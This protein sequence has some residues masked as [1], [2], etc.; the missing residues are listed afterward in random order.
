MLSIF[1]V[2]PLNHSPFIESKQHEFYLFSTY[3]SSVCTI[4][5]WFSFF[6]LDACFSLRTRLTLWSNRTLMVL[7]KS[8]QHWKLLISPN[9]F[10]FWSQPTRRIYQDFVVMQISLWCWFWNSSWSECC[11]VWF[12]IPS[13]PQL[14]LIIHIYDG[15]QKKTM[16]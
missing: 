10:N 2:L 9:K 7:N 8:G 4:L 13:V 6:T 1:Q 11:L 15:K 14:A 5:S 3:W 16:N 12:S